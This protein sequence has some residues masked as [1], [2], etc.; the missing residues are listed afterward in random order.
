VL[1][2]LSQYQYTAMSAFT[3]CK[4]CF[5]VLFAIAIFVVLIHGWI[6]YKS[7]VFSHEA[8]SSIALK[9]TAAKG[10]THTCAYFIGKWTVLWSRM[11]DCGADRTWSRL[12]SWCHKTPYRPQTMAFLRFIH[13]DI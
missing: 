3:C 5:I 4:R 13:A 7:Y 12:C 2:I 6:T 1:Q 8:V 9:Y 10:N 11:R